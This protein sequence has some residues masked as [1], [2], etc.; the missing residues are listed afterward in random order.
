M[1]ACLSGTIFND[2]CPSSSLGL[3]DELCSTLSSARPRSL[4]AVADGWLIGWMRAKGGLVGWLVG[5]MVGRD[6]LSI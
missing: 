6:M 1:S 5:W 2:L 3:Q 4:S